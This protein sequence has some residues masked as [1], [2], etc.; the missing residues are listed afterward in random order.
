MGI[1]SVDIAPARAGRREWVGLAA[2]ALG[3]LA[4]SFDIFVLLLA[5]PKLTSSLHASGTQQLWILDIYGFMVGGLLVTMGTLGDRIGRRR[6]LLIGAAAFGISSVVAA[7]S[8]SGPMLIAAR[9]V[10]GIAGATLA[11]STLALISNM[12]RDPKQMGS[13]IGIWAGAFTLGAIIGPVIGGVLLQHF[14][15]GSVFLLSVPI[16]G[17]LVLSGPFLLPEYKAP[18]AGR[19]DL[20]SVGL[21]LVAILPFIWGLKQLARNGWQVSALVVLAVGLVAGVTFVRRQRTLADPVLD[22]SLFRNGAFTTALIGLLAYSLLTGA[23]LLFL[24]Q[25]LQ[26]VNGLS[27]L[28]AGLSLLPGLAVGTVSVTTAPKLAGRFRPARLIAGGL[29][30]TVAGLVILAS[31]TG[32]ASLIVG[33]AVWCLGGGPVLALGIGLV[34]SSAPPEKAGSASSLPQISNELGNALGVAVLGALGTAVYRTTLTDRLPSGVTGDTART[35]IENVAGANAVAPTLA[36]DTA[37]ALTRAAHHAF[38]LGLHWVA[39]TAAALLA[40][41]AVLILVKLRH[42]PTLGAAAADQAEPEAEPAAAPSADAE[43]SAAAS[44]ETGVQ[45]A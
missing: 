42:V 18:S 15:W 33:F 3:S 17:L 23:A 25:H 5:L 6:L 43:D 19:L 12:F 41:T 35:A 20:A 31:T 30:L 29:V 22:V 37:A 4:V 14:W 11:P 28:A 13:A 7:Y 34:L 32:T 38:S 45:A 8:T 39:G 27:S 9:A 10:L 21:S 2:L 26:S 36:G 40:A 16:M 24:A 1:V 44:T